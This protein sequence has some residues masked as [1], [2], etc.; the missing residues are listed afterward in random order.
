MA[1]SPALATSASISR[2]ATRISAACALMPASTRSGQPARQKRSS[3]GVICGRYS[4]R[5]VNGPSG[6]LSQRGSFASMS[7]VA[8]GMMSENAKAPALPREV[9]S[10]MPL[11]SI[12]TTLRPASSSL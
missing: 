2:R 3:H 12:S 9:S 5:M 8:S 4:G 10:A 6:S 7:R 1:P 11:R